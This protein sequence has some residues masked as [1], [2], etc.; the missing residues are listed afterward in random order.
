MKFCSGTETLDL[1]T[2]SVKARAKA[3]YNSQI[4]QTK[5]RFALL[6]HILKQLHILKV[7]ENYLIWRYS[8][9]KQLYQTNH[10]LSLLPQECTFMKL[11]EYPRS[12]AAAQT[13][14]S[15][16][17]NKT[18]KYECSYFHCFLRRSDIKPL[19]QSFASNCLNKL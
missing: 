14:I 8:V 1:E 4:Q 13:T 17:V 15:L 12:F 3:S 2:G 18:N 9:R 19:Q 16:V 10:I 6:L 5:P 11:E 7:L